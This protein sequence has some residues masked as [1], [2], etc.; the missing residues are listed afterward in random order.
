MPDVSGLLSFVAAA[1]LVC[2]VPGAAVSAVMG[3]ALSRGL[4]AAAIVEL[5]IQA[6]RLSMVL[7]VAVALSTV[8]L[9]MA[10]AFDW[11]KFAGVGYLLWLGYRFLVAPPGTAGRSVGGAGAAGLFVGGFF[12]PWT[13]PKAILFFGALLPQFVNPAFP[14]WPQIIALGLLEMLIAALCDLGYAVAAA[15]AHRR[16]AGSAWINRGAGVLLIGAALW[17]AL[18]HGR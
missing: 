4:A 5:G 12:V 8:T 3:T 9:V 18:Q 13:N 10:A 15:Q 11:I 7:L 16:F 2:T 14:A 17:L 1:V 6:G